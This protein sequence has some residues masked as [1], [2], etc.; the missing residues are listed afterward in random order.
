MRDPDADPRTTLARATA[1][2]DEAFERSLVDAV[3]IAIADASRATDAN[4]IAL[5]TAETASALVTCLAGILAMSPAATRS[6]TALRR[7]IDEIGKRL[8]RRIASAER[9]PELADFLRRCFRGGGHG[10][11]H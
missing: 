1:G 9:S 3:T 4:C 8:R 5:R 11:H 6:P 10:P 2:Y 7:V